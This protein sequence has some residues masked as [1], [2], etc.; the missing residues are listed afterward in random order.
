MK[1]QDIS[2]D[3]SGCSAATM[4]LMFTELLFTCDVVKLQMDSLETSVFIWI[5]VSS[6]GL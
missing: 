1:L 4:V 3:T 6:N 5:L 2:A